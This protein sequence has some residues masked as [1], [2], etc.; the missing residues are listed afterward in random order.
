[1]RSSRLLF[2]GL[3][4]AFL[5]PGAVLILSACAT[6]NGDSVHGPQFG[7]VPERPDGSPADGPLSSEV[8]GGPA[9]EGGS[10]AP[11]DVGDGGPP[12]ACTA[13]TVAVLAGDDSS[14]S[15]AVQ[16]NG[17]AWTGATIAGGAAKSAPSLVAFG[18]GF[19][20]L[21]RGAGDALQAV[22]YGTSFS[23]AAA[24]GSLLTLGTPALA[25]VGT[26]A[27]AVFL[28]GPET[29]TADAHK[30]FRIENS[31]TT[32]GGADPV[33]AGTPSFG[34]S[35]PAAAA[36]GATL[37]MAQDGDN[38]K[39]YTQVWNGTWSTAVQIADP[40]VTLKTAPPALVAVTG[41]FDLVLLYSD[42]TAPNTIGFATRDATTSAWSAG[43][44]TQATAQ[45]AEQMSVA[46]LSATTL[47]VAFRGNNGR[48][49]TMLGTVG[50]TAITWG[51]PAPLLADTSTV[52]SA[53]AVAPGVCGDDAIA[54]FASG[55]IVKA[56]ELRANTWSVPATV[57]G[58]S[59]SRVSVATR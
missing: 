48:P 30:F 31:G 39:L 59:G 38:A 6:D 46:R 40:V 57:S 13:G 33:S 54:V 32:W 2:L 37:V 16:R 17:G 53:P 45:T 14:L 56:T 58:A 11:S 36:A 29:G 18:T 41:K 22:T 51:L 25:V 26:K 1:V 20:G 7:P 50:A 23:G 43:A 52:D 27:Q 15:G 49:Y 5:A 28:S 10:D 47:L 19:T 34:P 42:M 4:A 8:E 21:T 9:I 35:A 24:L 3:G 44:V 12:P 55:G